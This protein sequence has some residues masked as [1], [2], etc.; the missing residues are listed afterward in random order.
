LDL[1]QVALDARHQIGGIDRG[2][3]A[4]G[5]QE[6]RD[7]PL[8]RMGDGHLR[9]RRRDILVALAAAGYGGARGGEHGSGHH[10]TPTAHHCSFPRWPTRPL[11][12]TATSDRPVTPRLRS[13]LVPE[14]ASWNKLGAITDS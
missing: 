3:V 2:G 7:L 9:R 6:A 13:N 8:G 4:G 11:H 10:T 14:L 5:F 1:L 12:L